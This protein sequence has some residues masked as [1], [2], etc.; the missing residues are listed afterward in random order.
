MIYLFEDRKGRMEA[1]FKDSLDINTIKIGRLDCKKAE[2]ET[3]LEDHF[4]D[5]AAVLFHSSY[6]FIDHQITNEDVKNYF[7][8]KKIS[9][10]YFSGNMSN[11]LILENGLLNA[12]VNS[13]DM[14][15]NLSIFLEEYA[16]NKTINIPKLV[17]GEKYLINSLMELQTVINMFLF[18]KTSSHFLSEVELFEIMDLTEARL[19][20]VEFNEDK[21]KLLDWLKKDIKKGKINKQTLTN[22]IQRLID[23]YRN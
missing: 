19:K 8:R 16:R 12:N 14:Y 2:L 11:N 17:Y 20:E 1:Y 3:Y 4:A 7:K 22:Q 5:A 15:N 9:F 21:T 23:K 6:L 13:G 18:D 10:V